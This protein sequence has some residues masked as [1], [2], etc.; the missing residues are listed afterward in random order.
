MQT[1]FAVISVKR[2]IDIFCI[3]YT[4]YTTWLPL[5]FSFL[6][7]F[8]VLF[9]TS[10]VTSFFNEAIPES[11]HFYNKDSYESKAPDNILSK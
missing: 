9:V 1:I 6:I 5:T 7:I 2:T 4:T 8:Y 10:H 11:A 3:I